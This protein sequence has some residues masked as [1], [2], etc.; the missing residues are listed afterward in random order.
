MDETPRDSSGFPFLVQAADYHNDVI[1]SLRHCFTSEEPFLLTRL[2]AFSESEKAVLL[3]EHHEETDLRSSL[4]IL[5]LME[6]AFR[7]DYRYRCENRLKDPLSRA[8]RDKYKRKREKVSLE[9]EL[10]DAWSK[11]ESGARVFISELRG[12]FR[13]R[14]W[15]AH[16][17]YWIPKLG[18]KYDFNSLYGLA[19]AVLCGLPL[20]GMDAI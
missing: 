16:G 17:R 15:L 7:V 5:T 6:A 14:H 8:F 1:E 10:F 3:S 19:D 12:A 4:A 11:H 13:F 18:R 9:E 20:Y 2:G